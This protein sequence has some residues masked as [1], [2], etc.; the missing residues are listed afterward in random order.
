MAIT[1]PGYDDNTHFNYFEQHDAVNSNIANTSTNTHRATRN[2]IRTAENDFNPQTAFDN[3]LLTTS[4]NT[5]I[6]ANGSIVGMV[7]SFNVSESRGVNKLQAIGW[8][9]VVQ[10]VPENTKGGSL[11]M[12]RIAL[13]ES[14]IWN[15]LGLTT[16]GRPFNQIG[17]KV[18]DAEA[19]SDTWDQSSMAPESI[20]ARAYKTAIDLLSFDFKIMGNKKPGDITEKPEDGVY[21]Y[22]MFLEG[23]RWNYDED[24]L[25]TSLPK[26]LYT[27]VPMIHFIPVAN[28]ELPT[29]GVYFCPLYKVLS[30]AGTLSTTGHSTNYILFVELPSDKAQS[31]W[32]KAGVAM[33]LSLKQ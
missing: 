31:V 24:K 14:Q 32:I 22:G 13:Y 26:E 9:G 23:A 4:T 28:R 30:R 17:A 29:E 2:D 8:E 21:V 11:T 10:A 6:F 15:A 25:D 27:D 1:S 20:D 12:S 3:S 33:F 5:F 16:S 18:Y 19:E 7:Q